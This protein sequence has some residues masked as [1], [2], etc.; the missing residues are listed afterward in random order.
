MLKPATGD[1]W[2]M[3]LPYQVSSS[4][5][6]C[7]TLPPEMMP[8]P[9][10]PGEDAGGERRHHAHDQRVLADRRRGAVGEQDARLLQRRPGTGPPRS[11][12]RRRGSASA[13]GAVLSA[14]MAVRSS[15]A[16][17]VDLGHELGAGQRR[18]R[19]V[20]VELE[21]DERDDWR[22]RARRRTPR[23]RAY[24]PGEI[25]SRPCGPLSR[26]PS[27]AYGREGGVDLGLERVEV[28]VVQAPPGRG[29]SSRRT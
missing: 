2:S 4:L 15:S 22:G 3:L 23:R 27:R 12:G 17:R 10:G 14:R 29:R 28:L 16:C 24:S 18:R 1:V 9:A 11:S 8:L 6:N 21:R 25:W 5:K 26:M 7:E 20:D 13:V 19:G